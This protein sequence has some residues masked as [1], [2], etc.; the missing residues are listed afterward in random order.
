MIQAI[1]PTHLH[2]HGWGSLYIFKIFKQNRNI[3]ISSILIEFL[4][5]LGDPHGVGGW[6]HHHACEH[7][8]THANT[9]AHAYTH[10]CMLNMKKMAASMVVAICNFLTF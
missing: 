2:T 7:T 1:N 6:G 4:L 9:Y 3:S 8:H 10:A 5:I